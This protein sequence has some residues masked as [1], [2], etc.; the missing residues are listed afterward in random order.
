MPEAWGASGGAAAFSPCG[1]HRWWLVRHWSS[2]GSAVV[3]LG[4]NPSTA[5]G[6]QDDPTLRRLRGLARQWGHGR[7][8]VLNLF[9]RIGRDPAQLRR[10]PQP[11]GEH[12]DAWLATALAW[13]AASPPGSEGPPPRLWLGWGNQGGLHGRHRQ[14]LDQLRCW[15]G[16]VVCVGLTR[17]GQPRHPLYTRAGQP[18][19]PFV[20]CSP[21]CPGFH[22]VTPFT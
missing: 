18:P 5:T 3:F 11:V 16:E 2:A 22:A 4:L 6:R 1:H 9:S 12:N 20:G 14:V 13:L 10:C 19:L 7:L 21:P 15:N 17:K 8:L